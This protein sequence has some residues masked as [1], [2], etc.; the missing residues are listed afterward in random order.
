MVEVLVA[1]SILVIIVLMLGMLFQQTGLAWRTGSQRANNY[2]EVRALMGSL[3]RDAAAAVDQWSVNPEL[4]SALSGSDSQ[5][6]DGFPLAFFTLGATGFENGDPDATPLRALSY[7][8]YSQDGVRTE[9]TLMAN[10]S[11]YSPPAVNVKK[12]FSTS[13]VVATIDEVEAEYP[14]GGNNRLPL[15]VRLK[16]SITPSGKS[17]EIG[18]ESAGPD[19]KFGA[20]FSDPNGKDDIRTW[21]N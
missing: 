5:K 2:M 7:I 21:V 12:V 19:G 16:I 6:F 13:K 17:Y 9:R 20:T 8:T 14:T 11:A 4:R 3:Q 18:A 15:S 10:N 1:S